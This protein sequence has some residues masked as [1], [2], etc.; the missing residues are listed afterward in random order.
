[1]IGGAR[2]IL[3]TRCFPPIAEPPPLR[4]N[5]DQVVSREADAAVKQGARESGE[6]LAVGER[7]VCILYL[8]DQVRN[9]V[10]IH[11]FDMGQELVAL[12]HHLDAS[13]I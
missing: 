5:T 2:A 8:D 12:T 6:R 9:A 1:M 4:D 7:P 3:R 10:A 11:V 13:A